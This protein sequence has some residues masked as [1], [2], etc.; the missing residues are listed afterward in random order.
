M[1]FSGSRKRNP[2]RNERTKSVIALVTESLNGRKRIGKRS[3]F[4]VV[5]IF[6]AT[7]RLQNYMNPR[8]F[9]KIALF[10]VFG[11]CSFPAA[12]SEKEGFLG[13][14]EKSTAL[15]SAVFRGNIEGST[16]N[17]NISLGKR[18]WHIWRLEPAADFGTTPG[19]F[20]EPTRTLH[21]YPPF[22]KNQQTIQ[23]IDP[24]HDSEHRT[25]N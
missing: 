23:K 12:G 24:P 21:R 17:V 13:C 15:R 6:V 11:Q 10:A 2:E 25:I 19:V 22:G 14:S 20:L 5:H 8:G 3:G 18:G 16:E 9:F 1:Q 7:M 4:C